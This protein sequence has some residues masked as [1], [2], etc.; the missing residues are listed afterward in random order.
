MVDD[1][2]RRVREEF[3]LVARVKL[4]EPGAGDEGSGA[5]IDERPL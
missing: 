2:Q 4:V 3:D 1:I 5:V